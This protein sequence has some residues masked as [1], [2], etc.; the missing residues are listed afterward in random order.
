[1]IPSSRVLQLLTYA[2][3]L[4]WPANCLLH[5]HWELLSMSICLLVVCLVVL[6]D[7]PRTRAQVI[8]TLGAISLLA[9][10]P[11]LLTPV[12]GAE[13]GPYILLSLVIF[14][15]VLV[16]LYWMRSINDELTTEK[17]AHDLNNQEGK[18]P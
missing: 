11:E 1:M 17:K 18:Q 4:V 14:L 16:A 6:R 7:A 9:G 13:R 10:L 12:F 8:P 3:L 2:A 5:H 15:I